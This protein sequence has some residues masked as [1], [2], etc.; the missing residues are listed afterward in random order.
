MLDI[1]EQPG[2]ICA[3]DPTDVQAY[4]VLSQ[5]MQCH[6][7][8]VSFTKRM[9]KVVKI[10]VKND[11]HYRGHRFLDNLVLKDRYAYGP[12]FPAF[13]IDPDPLYRS[14]YISSAP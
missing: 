14:S 13:F 1:V 10:H 2:N 9:G 7:L 12:L 3:Y 8:A 11:V 5:F 6:V 4:T